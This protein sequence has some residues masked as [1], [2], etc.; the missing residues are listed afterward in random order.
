MESGAE[1]SF[2]N[3]FGL[4]QLQKP[5]TMEWQWWWQQLSYEWV[6]CP[7]S[8]LSQGQPHCTSVDIIIC[9]GMHLGYPRIKQE[10]IKWIEEFLKFLIPNS[11]VNTESNSSY[12]KHTLYGFQNSS[13]D[14]LSLGCPRADYE[15]MIVQGVDLVDDCRKYREGYQ[16]GRQEPEDRK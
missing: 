14:C 11:C 5:S 13:I 9:L 15:V 10:Y 8:V 1:R 3:C 16:E 2:S 4:L 7:L 12:W 6:T